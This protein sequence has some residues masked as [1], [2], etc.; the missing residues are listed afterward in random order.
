MCVSVRSSLCLHYWFKQISVQVA[1]EIFE[2]DNHECQWI[3]IRLR[4][5]TAVN[6][7]GGSYLIRFCLFPHFIFRFYSIVLS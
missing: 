3:N 6:T 4:N 1:S 7:A 2:A 5:F